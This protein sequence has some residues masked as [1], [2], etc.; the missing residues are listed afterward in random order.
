MIDAPGTDRPSLRSVAALTLGLTFLV[1]CASSGAPPAA[2]AQ[3]AGKAYR[4]GY[5][6]IPSRETAQDGANAFQAGLRELGWVEGQ[7]VVIEYRFADSNL[8]RL[9]DLA[10]SS[11]ACASMSSLREPRRP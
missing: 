8:E 2:W 3:Q 7:N 1:V 5:L 11:C 4:V 9:P 6:T 10:A